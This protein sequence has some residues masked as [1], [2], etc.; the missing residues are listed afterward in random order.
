MEVAA[1]NI[2]TFCPNNSTTSILACVKCN[3]VTLN[4]TVHFYI[5]I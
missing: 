5:L 4:A 3:S 1:F 2:F